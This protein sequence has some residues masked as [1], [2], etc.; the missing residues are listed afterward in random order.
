MVEL[1]R[2]EALGST[3]APFRVGCVPFLNAVPLIRGIE[4]ELIYAVPSE[5]AR[6]IRNEELDAAMVSVTEVLLNDRYD[7]LDGVAIASLGKLSAC[8]WLIENRSRKS[9]RFT[10][11]Q[12]LSPA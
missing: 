11:T 1:V 12:P 10:A 8:C 2:E 7:I 3:L 9:R 5:L 4:K 6:L